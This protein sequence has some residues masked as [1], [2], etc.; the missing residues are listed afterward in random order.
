MDFRHGGGPVGCFGRAYHSG[1]GAGV[2]VDF[3]E[4]RDF[5]NSPVIVICAGSDLVGQPNLNEFASASQTTVA[6]ILRLLIATCTS[7]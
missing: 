2:E 7:A 4:C 1:T 5:A 6:A 3:G